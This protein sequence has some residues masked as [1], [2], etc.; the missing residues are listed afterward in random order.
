MDLKRAIEDLRTIK[1]F[2]EQESGATPMSIEYAIEVLEEQQKL[3]RCKECKRWNTSGCRQGV[4]EC[5]WAYYMTKPDDFCSYG[6]RL[7]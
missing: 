1:E 4:G 7:E 3:V 6:E 5:E 2:F